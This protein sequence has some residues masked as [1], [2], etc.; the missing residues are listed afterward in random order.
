MCSLVN[1]QP[2][3]YRP[4]IR[5]ISTHTPPP[6]RS[7]TCFSH[8]DRTLPCPPPHMSQIPCAL[9]RPTT[10]LHFIHN[11]DAPSD[12]YDGACASQ[13][14]ALCVPPA[15]LRSACFHLCALASARGTCELCATPPDLYTCLRKRPTSAPGSRP[16]M[17]KLIAKDDIAC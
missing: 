8:S 10:L 4:H 14:Y 5:E 6:A 3:T 2:A 16:R 7:W 17:P 12:C 11:V 1:F 9:L 13:C 15:P